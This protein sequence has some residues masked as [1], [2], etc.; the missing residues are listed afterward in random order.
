MFSFDAMLFSSTKELVSIGRCNS[1][2]AVLKKDTLRDKQF[3]L[4]FFQ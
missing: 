3:G 2:D 4:R 1:P